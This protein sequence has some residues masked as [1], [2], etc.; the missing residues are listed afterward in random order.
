MKLNTY[1][2]LAAIAIAATAT[3]ALAESGATLKTVK[4]R[5][6]LIC[7]GHN[8]SYPGMTELDD[9]GNWA[10]F[11]V[12]L[13]RALATAIFG[14]HESHLDIVPTSWAQRWPSIQSGEV[15]AVIK[16]TGWTLN[17]DTEIGLQF[18]RPYMLGS[19]NYMAPVELGAKTP[20]DLDGGTLCLQSGTTYERYAVSHAASMGYEIGMVPFE[21]TE[22]MK[23]AFMAGRCDA[24]L[25]WD[26]QL[27]VFKALELPNP[28]DYA[29]I[30]APVAAEP[31]AIAMRQGDDNWVDIANWT[32]SVLVAAEE[33]GI[34]SANVDEMKANPPT[35]E[36]AKMLGATPGF[37][38]VLGLEDDFGYNI[39]K[40]IGNYAEIWDRNVGEGSVY[41]LPRGVNALLR[42]GGINY[43]LVID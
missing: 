3:G 41:K 28:D 17:R 43:P 14:T 9:R 37:G 33:Y 30:P 32:L 1:L 31:L 5:G 21:K 22:E 29:I 26:L 2:S 13:C 20:Q 36:V 11:D 24:I 7:T 25:E 12:D 16:S 38:T 15:D 42:D 4:E 19:V 8:G 23:A 10:G 40:V 6:K 27:A 35:P 18:S 39:I 34:T